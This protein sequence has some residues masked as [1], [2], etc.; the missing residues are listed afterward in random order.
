MRD[1]SGFV[2]AA[3]VKQWNAVRDLEIYKI[4]AARERE[5]AELAE[6]NA[7]NT[8]STNNSAATNSD[9][10][11]D[12]SGLTDSNGSTNISAPTDTSGSARYTTALEAASRSTDVSKPT[13]SGGSK[14]HTTALGASR[15]PEKRS[16][17]AV[18]LKIII[19][20]PFQPVQKSEPMRRI[21][22]L[23]R[24]MR[25]LTIDLSILTAK[26]LW[27]QGDSKQIWNR[28]ENIMSESIHKALAIESSNLIAK[29]EFYRGIARF[30]LKDWWGARDS[31][32]R[33]AECAEVYEEGKD[34]LEW[35]RKTEEMILLSPTPTS[36]PGTARAINSAIVSTWGGSVPWDTKEREEDEER[37]EAAEK[38]RLEL[39][40]SASSEKPRSY[41]KEPTS[42]TE[43][44][45]MPPNH[46]L[47]NPDDLLD[48][49]S[50]TSE[51]S[52]TPSKDTATKSGSVLRKNSTPDRA[53]NDE[54]PVPTIRFKP[55]LSS[56]NARSS[57]DDEPE[58][59]GRS[60]TRITKAS[61]RRPLRISTDRSSR[62]RIRVV[63]SNSP[64]DTTTK[65]SEPGNTARDTN[66]AK[67]TAQEKKET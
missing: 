1:L 18:P 7:E 38:E 52:K 45:G 59:I 20:R 26:T 3:T 33:A 19:R 30:G 32:M 54:A 67:D 42:N 40:K 24:Q 2:Y 23:K 28:M 55:A 29:C 16:E 4:K 46:L 43:K 48:G 25:E 15:S 31:F 12:M 49:G 64:K 63:K 22:R 62:S 66:G 6:R 53:A 50:S 41:S 10:S 39:A 34:A 65:S 9:R 58:R 27:L 35:Y 57:E 56:V 14:R 36:I 8:K 61:Q 21:G 44:P 51:N 17:T 11:T 13:D 47:S 5:K 37:W 60:A